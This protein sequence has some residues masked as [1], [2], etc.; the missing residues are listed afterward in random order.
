MLAYTQT[1][2]SLASETDTREPTAARY[3]SKTNYVSASVAGFRAAAA[4][5]FSSA[6]W[7]GTAW[8]AGPGAVLLTAVNCALV[9]TMPQ[10]TAAALQM[11]RGTL[12]AAVIAPMMLFG[13]YPRIDG[14]VM[15]CLVLAPVLMFG[16]W[17]T[18]RP[19]GMGFGLAYCILIAV[20]AGPENMTDYNVEGTLNDTLAV[21]IAMIIV[22]LACAVIF[23]PARPW[24]RKRLLRDLLDQVVGACTWRMTRARLIL[25]SHTR[26]I[27]HQLTA[28]SSDDPEFQATAASWMFTVLDVGHAVLELREELATFPQAWNDAED[29]C[30]SLVDDIA[31][32]FDSPTAA[33]LAAARSAV[34]KAVNRV[35]EAAKST[36][37]THEAR[38]TFERISGYLHFVRVTLAELPTPA[39]HTDAQE[40][41]R[42]F[43]TRH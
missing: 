23:P 1:Y 30:R 38:A 12:V 33:H 11:T 28:F 31:A 17:K 3:V 4:L 26:D 9:S 39:V 29:S 42:A 7:Y 32:L 13:V 5:L 15:L 40:W 25:E 10:P 36:R 35:R 41:L 20:L 18:T 2:A 24:L 34:D 43:L 21:V 22:L 14:Y 16:V 37:A 6:L 27:G 8:P 19:G